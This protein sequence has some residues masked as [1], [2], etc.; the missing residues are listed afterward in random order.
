[1]DIAINIISTFV[2]TSLIL[3]VLG[4]TFR[5]YILNYLQKNIEKYKSSLQKEITKHQIITE[6]TI[7]A[8][9]QLYEL[10]EIAYSKTHSYSSLFQTNSDWSHANEIDVTKFLQE[11]NAPCKKIEYFKQLFVENNNNKANELNTYIRSLNSIEAIND[12]NN[13]LKAIILKSIWIN[14]KIENKVLEVAKKLQIYF[15]DEKYVEDKYLLS[16]NIK[17]LNI[18]INEIKNDIRN[19]LSV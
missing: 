7:K 8:Y 17:K 10:L 9:C 18:V 16:E 5:S 11:K 2:S 3:A 14:E 13:L 12:I 19:E 15:I 1:M 6:E 4:F